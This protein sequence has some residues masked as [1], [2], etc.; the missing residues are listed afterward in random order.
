[1]VS[2]RRLPRRHGSPELLLECFR[3]ESLLVASYWSRSSACTVVEYTFPR[4]YFQIEYMDKLLKIETDILAFLA[5]NT[6]ERAPTAIG[7]AVVI[8]VLPSFN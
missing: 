6:K 3:H 7:L 8:W 4:H 5:R 2:S 1:M